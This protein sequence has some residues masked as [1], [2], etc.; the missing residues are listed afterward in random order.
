[1]PSCYF[2]LGS[3]SVDI[4]EGK[5]RGEWTSCGYDLH[6]MKPLPNPNRKKKIPTSHP[7]QRIV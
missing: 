7:K 3:K 5:K 6:N 1:M 2:G 4:A